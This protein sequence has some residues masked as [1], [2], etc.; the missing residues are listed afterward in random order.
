MK[1]YEQ[2]QLELAELNTLCREL[3]AQRPVATGAYTPL[4]CGECEDCHAGECETHR[5][6]ICAGC[7]LLVS[8]DDGCADDAPELCSHCWCVVHGEYPRRWS[9]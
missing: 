5:T 9:E 7:E 2:Q 1:S 8:W 3:E 6:F 4:V